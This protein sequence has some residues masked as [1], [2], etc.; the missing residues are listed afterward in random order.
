M[1]PEDRNQDS[2]RL[3]GRQLAC[4]G[5]IR[6]RFGCRSNHAGDKA[7]AALRSE[8]CGRQQR[9][10][11]LIRLVVPLAAAA[12][13]VAAVGFFW[14]WPSGASYF[15]AKIVGQESRVRCQGTEGQWQD[16]EIGDELR[17]GTRIETEP[18]A[19]VKL[20]MSDG[21]TVE[22]AGDSRF[23]VQDSKLQNHVLHHGAIYCAVRKRQVGQKP[24]VV[25]TPWGIRAEVVGTQFE[26]IVKASRQPE[27][28][29]RQCTLRVAEGKV[30]LVS[31]RE[32]V[33]D[34]GSL[35]ESTVVSGEAPTV[36]RAVAASTIAPWRPTTTGG[37][38]KPVQSRAR[39]GD[40]H[41]GYVDGKVLFQDDFE[42]GLGKWE[43]V[44]KKGNSEDYVS[45]PGLSGKGVALILQDKAGDESK[46]VVLDGRLFGEETIGIRLTLPITAQAFSLSFDQVI[47]V[48]GSFYP[49]HLDF[50]KGWSQKLLS[51]PHGMYQFR[52]GEWAHNR[53]DYARFRDASGREAL[54]AQWFVDGRLQARCLYYGTFRTVVL[55]FRTGKCAYDNIVIRERLPDKVS[56][57]DNDSSK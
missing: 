18:G 7:L 33:V 22:M 31:V 9:P 34:V 28:G 44:R 11:L 19:Y 57:L 2:G 6:S 50:Q 23:E 46:A 12:M 42:S 35:E 16:L 36:P 26:L 49:E 3:E 55:D 17:A 25:A 40:A 56:N 15:V 24:F 43:T 21:A 53:V 48:R 20:A 27:L 30:R 13:V 14:L 52:P 39:S 5:I 1:A 8:A 45:A 47:T 51:L 32:S 4:E 37:E 41:A 29:E 38:T 54:D 10:G